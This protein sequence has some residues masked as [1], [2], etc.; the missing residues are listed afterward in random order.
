VELLGEV[1]TAGLLSEDVKVILGQGMAILH[2]AEGMKVLD[3]QGPP[4]VLDPG[5]QMKVAWQGMLVA[6]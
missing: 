6:W 5:V 3:A 1:D 2:L 4:L